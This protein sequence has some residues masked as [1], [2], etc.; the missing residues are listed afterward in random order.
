[1]ASMNYLNLAK[2]VLAE[3]IKRGDTSPGLDRDQAGRLENYK[4]WLETYVTALVFEE[5]LKMGRLGEFISLPAGEE[6]I[7]DEFLEH[8]MPNYEEFLRRAA[9][10]AG[11]A[12]LGTP[13]TA[14]G[15]SAEC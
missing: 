4:D 8:I 11:Y 2:Q 1:M 14:R 5:V 9:N 13:R 6:S 15:R 3:S 7:R 12:L 10:E